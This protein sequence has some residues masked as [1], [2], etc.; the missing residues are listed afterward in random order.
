M[1]VSYSKN[2]LINIV[3]QNLIDW[4]RLPFRKERR[5]Y[6]F[7]YRI[8]GFFPHN[9]SIYKVAFRH[10]SNSIHSEDGG[11]INNERLEFL[12]DAILDAIVGHIVYAH[13]AQK[14]EGFLTN[15]RSKVVQ[16]AM[17]NKLAVEI[18]LDKLIKS[19]ANQSTHNSYICGN[20]F[21]AFVGAVYLDRGY[22]Y[23]MM[24]I[25]QKIIGHYIN[26]DQ[27][28]K[29]EVNFKSRLIEWGQK[30]KVDII[31]DLVSQTQDE[32]LNP[33]FETQ[34]LVEGI[35]AGSGTGY[36]K[37]ESQQTASKV[38]LNRLRKKNFMTQVFQAK[39]DRLQSEVSVVEEETEQTDSSEYTDTA[40][41]TATAENT[42]TEST[43]D[44]TDSDNDKS[45]QPDIPVVPT[46]EVDDILDRLP[47]ADTHSL[48]FDD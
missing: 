13:F 3:L 23:C 35:T 8:L 47:E 48:P 18:G 1:H 9:I 4:I 45:A 27:L 36:S 37:K 28:S 31:F 34:I 44:T 16:R 43:K 25:S 29:T 33:T 40:E 5:S 30:N 15:T 32:W 22:K 26:L 19:T 10:K 20:A 2:T 21:E 17:L 42:D 12:G 41:E 39:E 6:L 7:I 38:A 14:G 11:A 46:E 24:F